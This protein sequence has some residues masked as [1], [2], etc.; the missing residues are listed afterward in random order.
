[1][2]ATSTQRGQSYGMSLV[3]SL[4]AIV[5]LMLPIFTAA[6]TWQGIDFGHAVPAVDFLNSIGAC[7]HMGQGADNP[8]QSGTAMAYAGIRCFRDDQC[9]NC[10]SDWITLC[11]QHGLRAVVLTG[12]DFSITTTINIAKQFKAA[13]VLLAVEGP[14]EPNNWHVTYQGQTSSNTTSLPIAKYQRDLYAAVKAEPTLSDVPVFHSSESGGSEPDN[15][16]L[17]FLTI[18]D[19]AG[20]LMPDGTVFADYANTHNYV[21]GTSGGLEDNQAWNAANPILNSRWD[22]MWVEYHHT[23]WSPGYDGYTIE[24]LPTIPRVTTE[25]GWTTSG[26]SRDITEEQQGRLFLNLYLAQFKEGWSYTFIY[27]LKDDP[28]QGYWGLFKTDYTAKKAGLYLHNMTTILADTGTIATPGQ[29]DYSIPNQPATVHDLLLQKH[30]GTFELVVWGE[31]ISGSSAVTMNLGGTVSSV[32]IY[33]PVLGTTA[34][35]TLTSVSSIP[36]TLTDHPLILEIQSTTGISASSGSLAPNALELSGAFPNPFSQRTSIRYGLPVSQ[37]MTLGIYDIQG[38]LVK[39]LVNGRQEA[40]YHTVSFGQDNL[41]SGVYFMR[42]QAKQ[43]TL[44]QKL[45]FMR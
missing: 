4:V 30:D 2:Q 15:C 41:V 23:W 21:C 9:A 40:G 27:M 7:T 24:Q 38:K 25:T 13:G 26:G 44:V 11:H 45:Q 6:Q 42:M 36:I 12:Y 32:K 1:M 43:H 14:N 18:P 17:Q 28:G 35:Q 16:G 37:R 8:T 20:C 3:F 10:V 19:G 22:G 33:D 5:S 39:R 29:L 34:T 31:K